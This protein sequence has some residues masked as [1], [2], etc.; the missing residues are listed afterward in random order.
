MN[1]EEFLEKIKVESLN[2]EAETGRYSFNIKDN[3]VKNVEITNTPVKPIVIKLTRGK[4]TGYA[5]YSIEEENECA[6]YDNIQCECPGALIM[7]PHF[8]NKRWS[9]IINGNWECYGELTIDDLSN[10]TD[11]QREWMFQY[12]IEEITE[13]MKRDDYY[14]EEIE[15]Y[16][17]MKKSK[18]NLD[19]I[20]SDRYLF[21]DMTDHSGQWWNIS[22]EGYYCPWDTSTRTA[23]LILS[24]YYVKLRLNDRGKFKKE[25][26]RYLN[27]LSGYPATDITLSV[28]LNDKFEVD[29][30]IAAQL[31]CEGYTRTLETLWYDIKDNSKDF[32]M[33]IYYYIEDTLRSDTAWELIDPSEVKVAAPQVIH[34]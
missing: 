32:H 27:R 3:M 29:D 5:V 21:L 9:D 26:R 2:E 25:I 13:E 6:N 24:D 7:N 19:N 8:H 22:G 23:M 33:E 1:K 16:K 31:D 30:D 15:T 28:V 18:F 12:G 20:E 11:I 14:D 10:L 4:V 34:I 17:E